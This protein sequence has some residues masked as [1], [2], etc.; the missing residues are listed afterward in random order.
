MTFRLNRLRFGLRVCLV[1]CSCWVLHSCSMLS[2]VGRQVDTSPLPVV[3]SHEKNI[4][5]LTDWT[6]R[7]RIS[8]KTS[9]D[10]FS[11][12]L[13]WHQIGDAYNVRMSGPFGR[14]A[15]TIRGNQSKVILMTSDGQSFMAST[16]E[17]LMVAQLGWSIPLSR[18]RY[19]LLGIPDR[20]NVEN[21]PINLV[22]ESGRY[23]SFFQSDCEIIYKDYYDDSYPE[24][25]RK[26]S[27]G[28][29]DLKSRIVVKKWEVR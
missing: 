16:P 6:A 15:L 25:P 27:I 20:R 29:D 1:A 28:C 7:L 9:V 8:I 3:Q 21:L 22:D 10:S 5:V 23:E 18:V 12:D 17:E 13:S 19:W 4:M 14:G 24:L 26:M 2:N 11:A